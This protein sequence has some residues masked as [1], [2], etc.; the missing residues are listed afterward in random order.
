MVEERSLCST[1]GC[2]AKNL[3]QG[4]KEL[5]KIV[6]WIAGVNF[7]DNL[8]YLQIIYVIHSKEVKILV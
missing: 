8:T 1:T 3:I 5:L 2:M 4:S 6:R 7:M